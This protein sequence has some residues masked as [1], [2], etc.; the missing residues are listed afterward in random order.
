MCQNFGEWVVVGGFFDV[1]GCD[2]IFECCKQIV[3]FIVNMFFGIN[4][5]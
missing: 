5:D 4:Y 3:G 2:I 1:L